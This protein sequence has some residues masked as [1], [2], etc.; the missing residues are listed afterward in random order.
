[1]KLKKV[2][3]NAINDRLK[4][5]T[6][7]ALAKEIGISRET[8]SRLSSDNESC[9]GQRMLE[10]LVLLGH[11]VELEANGKRLQVKKDDAQNDFERTKN[12]FRK[13]IEKKAI[14]VF[15]SLQAFSLTFTEKPN[16]VWATINGKASLDVLH[17]I[18]KRLPDR[19]KFFVD[20]VEV[21]FHEAGVGR[22]GR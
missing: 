5:M 7:T 19:P 4:N 2:A 8:L 9:R 17:N 22:H 13:F 16:H 10:I 1:M 11:E 21:E 15:S 18:A 6:V 12:E 3:I 14:E 20:G